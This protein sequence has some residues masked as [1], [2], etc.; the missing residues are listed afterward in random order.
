MTAEQ[1]EIRRLRKE[2]KQLVT[3]VSSYLN[4]K[5]ALLLKNQDVPTEV[6]KQLAHLS[7]ILNLSNDKARYFGLGEPLSNGKAKQSKAKQRRD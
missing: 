3:I 6:G 7:N 1:K 2:L 5:D 4:A